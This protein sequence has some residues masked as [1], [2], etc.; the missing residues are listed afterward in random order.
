MCTQHTPLAL[1]VGQ[2]IHLKIPI[3][4]FDFCYVCQESEWLALSVLSPSAA[5][6][7]KAAVF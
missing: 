7:R 2:G 3:E 5:L 1:L 6:K 4:H